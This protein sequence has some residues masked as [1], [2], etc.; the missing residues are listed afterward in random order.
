MT[1]DELRGLIR[2][3]PIM[4]ELQAFV[5]AHEAQKRREADPTFVPPP[6][7][8][9]APPPPAEDKRRE[10]VEAGLAAG[11]A[12]HALADYVARVQGERL[13]LPSDEDPTAP[14][15]PMAEYTEHLRSAAPH[16][17]ASAPSSRRTPDPWE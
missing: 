16:L 6:P 5:D 2:S 9:L 7:P 11:V 10:L 4:V 12:E 3:H 8:S 15:M 17:F 1:D 14:C 13:Q